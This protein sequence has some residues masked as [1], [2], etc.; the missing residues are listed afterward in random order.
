MRRKTIDSPLG[1]S[2]MGNGADNDHW[3]S[4]MGDATRNRRFSTSSDGDGGSL[5]GHHRS[6]A[7]RLYSEV[8]SG[9]GAEFVRRISSNN[10]VSPLKKSLIDDP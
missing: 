4:P 9:G 10:D 5:G 8:T 6:R 1:N 3:Q 7:D 2:A